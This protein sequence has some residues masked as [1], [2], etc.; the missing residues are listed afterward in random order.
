M[1]DTSFAVPAEKSKRLG[2]LYKREPWDGSGPGK[3]VR[4]VTVDPGGSGLV[5]D[6]GTRNVHARANDGTDFTAPSASVFLQGQASKIIQGGGCVC[7]VAGGLVS[8]LRDY[9]RFA[10]MLVND[11][12]VNGVRLL[13]PESV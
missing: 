3:K 2:A 6:D 12:E 7:S 13:R 5:A 4:F 11:G 1:N 8:S 10:Q 9:A